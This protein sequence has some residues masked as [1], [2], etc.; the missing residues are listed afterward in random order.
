MNR[1]YMGRGGGGGVCVVGGEGGTQ[2]ISYSWDICYCMEGVLTEH[3][4]RETIYVL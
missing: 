4:K 2:C 3:D 1:L